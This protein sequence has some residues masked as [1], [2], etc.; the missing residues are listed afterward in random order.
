MRLKIT[1]YLS[2]VLV[3][4]STFAFSQITDDFSDGNFTSNPA[5]NGNDTDF[6]VNANHQL[7]LNSSGTGASYLAL[8]NTQPLNNCEWSFGIH[9]NFS[10]SSSNYARVYLVS[11]QQNISG[12]LNGYYLQFGENGSNDQV[13]LFLQSGSTSFSV[14]RGTTNIANAFSLRVKV[15]R[16]NF[17]L[18]KL[19]VDPT[20]GTNYS[21]EASGTDNTFSNTNFFGVFCKYTTTNATQFFFDDFYIYAPPDVTPASLDS[22]KIISHNQLD[23]YFSEALS[24]I[25]AQTI[26]NY[27]VN[28]GIGFASA[29]VQDTINPELV[30]LTLGNNFVSKQYY[31]LTATGV[32]DLAGN[33]TLNATKTFFYFSPAAND[34]VINEIMA[35]P[36]PVVG[37]PDYEYVELFNRTHYPVNLNNWTFS[38]SSTIKI[39]PNIILLPDSFLI[40]C[41]DSA[42]NLFQSYGPTIGLFTS[43]YTLSNTGDNLILRNDLENII[44]SVS[45]NATWYNDPIKQNGGWSLEQIDANGSCSGKAN[46]KA[47]ANNSG[48]TPGRK[49]SVCGSNPDNIP[50]KISHT[51]VI[52]PTI[53]QLFFDEYMD[54]TTLMNISSYTI[55]NG[56]GNPILADPVGPDY[57]SVLLTLNSPITSGI[58]YTVTVSGAKDCAGNLIASGNTGQF[59]IAQPASANDIVINEVMFDPKVN[60]VEWIEIYNRSEKVIDLTE[61]YFCSQDN[62]GNLNYINQ[63]A[64]GGYLILPQKYIILSTDGSAIKSQYNTPNAE[65]FIDMPSTPSLNNDSD[66]VLLVNTSQTVI[67]KLHYYSSWHLPLLTDTKGISLERINYDH[68][69]QDASNWHSAAESVGGATP[70]YKNSQYT[71]GEEGTEVTVSPE[72]FSPDNDGYNDVLSINYSFDTPGMVGDVNIYDSRGRLTKT[73]VRNELLASSGTFFW[74]GITDEKEKAHIGIYIVWFEAFDTKG[75]VKKY[76]KTCVVAGKL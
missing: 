26:A 41:K 39:F 62:F 53:V 45:Y 3:L 48:G 34:V 43:V 54:S 17:G 36:D 5:W 12:T 67:D 60:G 2:F 10:P 68:P 44:N 73:L 19:F 65:G 4:F 64:P 51:A 28:N 1:Y 21:Q 7:Q 40:L 31:T 24:T 70:A 72:V 9:L 59:A 13:E 38:T 37:L 49:N 8:T 58:I 57:T 15:T 56:I 29:A 52:S 42:A 33:N 66:Y 75:K 46:W 55:D 74:D 69:T 50:P 47:S 63:V 14:C 76:K 20:G 25:S 71:N 27:S 61:I 30:H 23:A 11:N 6:I 35:D 16:D 18:W 32:Q 22:V